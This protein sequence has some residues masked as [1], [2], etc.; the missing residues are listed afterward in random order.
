MRWKLGLMAIAAWCLAAVSAARCEDRPF[1]MLD[2]GGHQA[3]IRGVTFTPDGK[4][5]VSAGQDKVVRVY[6]WRAGKTVRTIRGQ[7]GPGDEGKIYAM[8]LSPDGRWLA[9]GGWMSP[10]QGVRDEDIGDIRLY[11]F[12]AGELKAIL[13]APDVQAIYALAFSRDSRRLISGSSQNAATIWDVVTHQPLHSPMGGHKDVVYGVAFSTDGARAVTASRDKTLRLWNVAN[14][15]LVKEMSGH[16]GFVGA[17]AVSPRD[18]TIASG[19]RSGEIRLWDGRTGAARR[20][21]PFARVGGHVTSLSFSPDGRSL[22]ATCADTGC[23]FQQRVFD[24]AS[25]NTLKVYSK[26]RNTVFG[27]AFSADGQLVATAGDLTHEIHIWDPRSGDTKAVLKGTGRPALAVGFSAD[28]RQFGWGS[29]ANYVGHNDRAPLEMTL[30]LPTAAEPIGEPQRVTSQTGWIRAQE[31]VGTWSLQHRPGGGYGYDDA[32]L[33]IV[34]DGQI[35]ASI[36]RTNTDGYGH[37]SYGFSP[38][39]ETTF[40]GAADGVLTA[41]RRDGAKVGEFIGHNDEVWS[42]AVSPDGRYLVSG[43][44]DQ[45]VRLWDVK[46][47]ELLVSLFYG[48][49]GEWVMWTPEGF[50]TRSQKGGDRVG[51]QINH[52]P[53]KAADYVTGEQV[54]DTFF[55]PDLVAA[56]IAGDPDGKVKKAAAELRIEE[57]LRSGLAPEV[58]IIGPV[59]GS[60]ADDI[61]VTVTARIVDKGGGIGRIAWRIKGQEIQVHYGEG[62][63]NRQGEIT[64]RF[65]LASTDNKIEVVAE[66]KSGKVASRPAGITVKVDK[67]TLD[68]KDLP[69]LYILALGVNSYNDVKRKLKFAVSDAE[70]LSRSLAEAGKNYYRHAPVVTVLR[71]DQVSAAAIGAA[72]KELGT[73]V[74]ANDVFLFFLAGHG[75]MIDGDYYFVPGHITAFTDAAIAEQGFGSKQWRD[76]FANIKAQKSVWIFDTCDAGAA[77]RIFRATDRPEEAAQQRMKAATGRVMFMASSDQQSANEGY[78]GHGILTYTILEGLALAGDEKNKMISLGDLKD[79]VEVKVPHYSRAMKVCQVVREQEYCQKPVVPLE[80]DNYALVP[81]YPAVLARLGTTAGVIPRTPTHAVRAGTADLMESTRGGSVKRK[82][83]E[84]FMLTLITED[85]EWAYVA[86]DGTALGYVRKSQLMKLD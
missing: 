43:A 60:K 9:V 75:K 45:T 3:F 27:A 52:G 42:L 70:E 57:V 48:S 69:D 56:K 11:D 28:G 34:Q 13:K 22:L 80:A 66:N 72:F 84:G 10:G 79:Y 41:F 33:D 68:A 74:K 6:D 21:D 67:R 23:S 12:A 40:S 4:H 19:D 16:S 81:R 20:S 61:S 59:D 30:R 77:V 5:L 55:R 7:V 2:T 54:R 39:G 8:A 25:G 24:V 49:D 64:A 36:T 38:D 53:D 47:R 37:S 76:W 85:G 46:S 62:A 86:R 1:L 73:K 32:T 35:R 17:V 26:H 58:T 15:A 50:F 51:W 18:G 65:E 44:A 31:R 71:D 14:G 29:A 78:Q 63:L 83:P 82:L